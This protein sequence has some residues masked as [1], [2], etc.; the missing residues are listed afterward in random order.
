MLGKACLKKNYNLLPGIK[1]RVI[2][3]HFT[4]H[5]KSFSV[6]TIIVMWCSSVIPGTVSGGGGLRNIDV[7]G[8][9]EN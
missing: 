1:I 3:S 2:S 8:G 4:L 6:L 9:Y 7:P 5:V